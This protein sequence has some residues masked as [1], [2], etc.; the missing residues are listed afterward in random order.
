MTSTPPGPGK[1]AR[2]ERT[3]VH[4]PRQGRSLTRPT[5][6][7]LPGFTVAPYVLVVGTVD[8]ATAQPIRAWLIWRVV[9]AATRGLTAAYEM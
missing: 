4:R 5:T 3:D 2:E 7:S 1:A 6:T 9:C 8:P